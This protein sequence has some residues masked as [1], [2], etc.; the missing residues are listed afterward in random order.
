MD[1]ATARRRIEQLTQADQDPTLSNDEVDT[2]LE[3]ARRPDIAG[4]SPQNV[5]TVAEWAASTAIL[6]GTVVVT[7]AGRYWRCRVPG[8]TGA[9]EPTWPD[10]DG[11]AVSHSPLTDGTV[12]WEDFG[13]TWAPTFDLSAAAAQGWRMKA[14]K[15]A[16]RFDFAEDGQ[17][18]S[19]SQVVAHCTA[20]AER[21][22]RRTA[23]SARIVRC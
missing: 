10:L 19:R 15:A 4:N 8:T 1:E 7:T 3:D 21:Y 9:T 17:Q 6:A 2:L 18:F 22:E 12:T 11:Y 16:G 13:T 20:M 5:T 14:G 23:G